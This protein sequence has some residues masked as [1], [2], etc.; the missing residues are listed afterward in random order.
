MRVLI[1]CTGNSCR[2]QMAEAFLRS[3]APELEVCSAGTAP[4][5]EVHPQAI[6]V[7]QEAGL[8]IRSHVPKDVSRYLSEPFDYVIT[9]CDRARESCPHFTGRVRER[10][11]IGF[12]DPAEF[13]GTE[14]EV[15]AEFRRVRDEI[16]DRFE[17][18]ARSI[19]T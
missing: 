2:S 7:M 10:L 4:A 3:F 8:N 16:R 6:A 18:F 13:R 15:L 14:G 17:L 9:V 19:R 11:H 5:Q 1:L 12:A